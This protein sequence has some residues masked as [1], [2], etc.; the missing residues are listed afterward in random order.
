MKLIK[1]VKHVELQSRDFGDLHGENSLFSHNLA[2]MY[3]ED[4]HQG[5]VPFSSRREDG[6]KV[7]VFPETESDWASGLFHGNDYRGDSLSD[8]FTKFLEEAVQMLIIDGIAAYEIRDDRETDG[9]LVIRPTVAV[10]LDFWA[11]KVALKI[12]EPGGGEGRIVELDRNRIFLIE[13]PSWIEAGNGFS[14]TIKNLIR[15][16]KRESAPVEHLRRSSEGLP[17][18]FEYSVFR[19]MQEL[20]VLRLTRDSGWPGRSLYDRELTEFYSIARFLRFYFQGLKLRDFLLKKINEVLIPQLRSLGG[21][22]DSISISG[23]PTADDVLE[24][25]S[26]L[27]SGEIGFKEALDQTKRYGL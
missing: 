9:Q 6:I 21:E 23:V 25:Q 16:S 2:H 15:E 3:Y 19:K 24:I 17:N 22:I 12:Y 7:N 11:D 8:G 27:E 14:L 20:R 4:W 1:S 10:S 26:K 13:A 18:Y 5:I